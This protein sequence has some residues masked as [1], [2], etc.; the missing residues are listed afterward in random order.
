MYQ[1]ISLDLETL[2]VTSTAVVLSIGA[3]AFNLA[4]NDGYDDFT[5]DR[6]FYTQLKIQPQ[7]DYGRTISASTLMWWLNQSK[8]AQAGISDENKQRA[9]DISLTDFN[10]FC[11]SN[12]SEYLI[13]N[14]NMFDNAILRSLYTDEGFT[15]PFRFWADL[16]LRTM[17]VMANSI[18]PPKREGVHHNA[19]DDAIFQALSAQQYFQTIHPNNEG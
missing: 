7:L 6:A 14:G 17:K 4:D 1:F 9:I 15:F 19:L 12:K 3:A 2:D 18:K 16:D 11:E 8:A 10:T 5:P 13:G